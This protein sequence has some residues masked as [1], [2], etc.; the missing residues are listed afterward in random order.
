MS[1]SQN[2]ATLQTD[3]PNESVRILEPGAFQEQPITLREHID[4]DKHWI[5]ESLPM[6]SQAHM[7][8]SGITTD[9]GR[10][11]FVARADHQ[12][13]VSPLWSIIGRSANQTT[14]AGLNYL[15]TLSHAG[16][17]NLILSSQVFNLPV[18][19]MYMIFIKITCA[20]NGGGLFLGEAEVI[21]Y[22]NNGASARYLLRQSIYDIPSTLVL[23]AFDIVYVDGSFATPN[24]QFALATNDTG[25]TWNTQLDF[26][27]VQRMSSLTSP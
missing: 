21:G 24:Y 6:P 3:D 1:D 26:I 27:Y 10:V 25:A 14:G 5:G 8:A 7:K 13:D 11:P 4:P 9:V 15:N 19:G 2:Q 17:R 18:H 16:G 20:R 22:F 23:E 12:H